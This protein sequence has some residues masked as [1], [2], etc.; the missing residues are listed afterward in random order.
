MTAK[1][2]FHNF[3]VPSVSQQAFDNLVH[4]RAELYDQLAAMLE[5]S[6][7]ALQLAQALA[8]WYDR[9]LAQERNQGRREVLRFIQQT[10]TEKKVH[11]G[12]V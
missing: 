3:R 8:P 4:R 11:N 6:E 12:S 2:A 1:P 7:E 5:S 10:P 9:R